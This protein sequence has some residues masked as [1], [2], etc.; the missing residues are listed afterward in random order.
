MASEVNWADCT[1]PHKLQLMDGRGRHN[2]R[3]HI[4]EKEKAASSPLA[5]G[6]EMK[7]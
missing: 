2:F 6:T 5:E 1:C 4:A 3:C 7:Q